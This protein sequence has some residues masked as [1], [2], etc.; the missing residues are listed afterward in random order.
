MTK[1]LFVYLALNSKLAQCRLQQRAVR[2]HHGAGR[3]AHTLQHVQQQ[4]GRPPLCLQ[5]SVGKK[6]YGTYCA[7]NFKK[8]YEVPIFRT[9]EKM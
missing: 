6:L 2:P 8:C 3:E 4:D 7:R 9:A 1:V 5:S